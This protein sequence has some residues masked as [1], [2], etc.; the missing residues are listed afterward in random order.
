MTF[1]WIA[2]AHLPGNLACSLRGYEARI[3]LSPFS[4]ITIVFAGNSSVYEP[5]LSLERLKCAEKQD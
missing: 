3:L 2:T 4:E 5:C 1:F